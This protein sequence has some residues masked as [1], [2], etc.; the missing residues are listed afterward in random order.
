MGKQIELR[1]E[2]VQEV[3]GRVPS[4]ILRYGIRFLAIML[5]LLFV[6][7]WIFKYPDIISSTLIL[8]TSTPPAG[9]VAKTNG[10]ITKLFVAD[11]QV[12]KKGDCL[13][14]IENAASLTDVQYLEKEV[15]VILRNVSAEKIHKMNRKEWKLGSIQSAFSRVYL[16]LEV[17]NQFLE[18]NFYPRKIQSIKMLL[19]ANKNHYSSV[20]KQMEIISKQHALNRRS[21]EREAYL[22]KQNLISEEESDKAKDKLLQSDMNVQNI[23]STLENLKIQILQME[24]SLVDVEQQYLEKKTALILDLNASAN[25]LQN[26]IASWKMTYLLCSPLDGKITFTNYWCENQNV[27]SNQVVFSIVPEAKTTLIGKAELPE[28][29]SG[30]VK[31]GQRVNIRFINYPENEFGI[32]KGVVRKIS[33][34]PVDGKYSVEITFPDGLLTTY[35]KRLPLSHEMTGT[36]D[37][38]TDELRLLDQFLLPVKNI[39]KNNL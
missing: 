5:V 2:E 28:A 4:W 34:I 18:L 29:R 14:V 25:Q 33:L 39:F 9:V 19:Q 32:V 27:T 13:A 31:L 7:S 26:E 3:L 11:Q 10:K 30:K 21:F 24:E 12:V 35:G 22:K 15:Q 38:I 36:A 37:I 8:T 1:S 17:Y 16:N 20:A 23:Q 6:G